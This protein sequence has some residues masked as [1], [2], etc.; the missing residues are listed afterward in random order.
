MKESVKMITDM[1]FYSPIIWIALLLIICGIIVT[2]FSKIAR[3]TE[4]PVIFAAGMFLTCGVIACAGAMKRQLGN[5]RSELLN[6]YQLYSK[7]I[8]IIPDTA[9]YTINNDL[10]VD[11]MKHNQQCQKWQEEMD[12]HPFLY[13]FVSGGNVERY[14]LYIVDIPDSIVPPDN[15]RK[16]CETL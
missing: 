10:Y 13:W 4:R 14:D 1:S 16:E 3:K 6:D 5:Q 12:D 9:D 7:I 11:V 15:Q 8:N 2:I